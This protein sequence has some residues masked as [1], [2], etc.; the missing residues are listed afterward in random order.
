MRMASLNSPKV[1]F[2]CCFS[3]P[4]VFAVLPDLGVP[5]WHCDADIMT[6]SYT[7][8]QSAHQVKYADFKIVAA[9]GDSLTVI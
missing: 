9:L 4:F 5:G 7:I 1:L 2:L 8:P 6:P 3:I